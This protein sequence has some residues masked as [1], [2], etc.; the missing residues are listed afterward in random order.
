VVSVGARDQGAAAEWAGRFGVAGRVEFRHV[1]AAD[2][3]AAEGAAYGLAVV[4]AGPSAASVRGTLEA[5]GRVLGPGG[6]VAVRGYPDPDGP[7]VRAVVDDWADRLGWRRVA[8]HGYLGVF[9]GP[10][11]AAGPVPD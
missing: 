2:V 9:Q 8:Q 7:E 4:D 10:A 5:A 6:R 3:L 11:G 1:E